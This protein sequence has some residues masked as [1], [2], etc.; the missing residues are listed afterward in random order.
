MSNDD[1]F[2]SSIYQKAGKPEPPTG[3]DE[4]ILTASRNAVDK[5]ARATSPFAGRWPAVASIAAVIVI[6]VILVPILRQEQP[7]QSVPAPTRTLGTPA[8]STEAA[9]P[10]AVRSRDARK[11]TTEALIPA[12]EPVLLPQQNMLSEEQA[13][14]MP[15]GIG[16]DT[17]GRLYRD[18]PASPDKEED[19]EDATGLKRSIMEAADS[20]PFAILTPEMWEAKLLQLIAADELEQARAELETLLAADPDLEVPDDIRRALGLP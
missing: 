20:A 17:E 9:A 2:I 7:Q 1:E 16:S 8:E 14:P 19:A 15:A 18:E 11:K 10:G 3:L 6:T 5:P 12:S 13:M 4:A